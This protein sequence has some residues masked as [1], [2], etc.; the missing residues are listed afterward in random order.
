MENTNA[1]GNRKRTKRNYKISGSNVSINNNG[2]NG[3]NKGSDR[4][5]GGVG[6]GGDTPLTHAIHR[7]QRGRNESRYAKEDN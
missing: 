7:N 6:S 4:S 3:G 1:G 2:N 5:S